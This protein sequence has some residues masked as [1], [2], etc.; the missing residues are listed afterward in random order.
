MQE[1]PDCLLYI[2][3]GRHKQN[4]LRSEAKF[5][6]HEAAT[7]RIFTKRPLR[8]HEVNGPRFPKAQCGASQAE[9]WDRWGKSRRTTTW[10]VVTESLHWNTRYAI[11]QRHKALHHKLGT[12]DKR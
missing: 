12:K 1:A 6:N 10:L 3:A 8:A 11:T 2:V 7:W 9:H 4:V 5:H